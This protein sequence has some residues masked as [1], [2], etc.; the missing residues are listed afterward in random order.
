M[1]DPFELLPED[2]QYLDSN[3]LNRWRKEAQS[4][5]GVLGLFI[6]NFE[7]PSGYKEKHSTLMIIVPSGYPGTKIDMF[8]FYPALTK[9]NGNKIGAVA[10]ANQFNSTWQQW[11]R[12]YEWEPGKDSIVSHI[13]YIKRELEAEVQK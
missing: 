9:S 3:Y 13:E 8:F 1:S 12:H 4:D 6:D 5:S 2:V 11:S 7:I 10:Q